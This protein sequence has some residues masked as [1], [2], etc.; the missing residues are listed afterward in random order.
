MP[1]RPDSS[2]IFALVVVVAVFCFNLLC[3]YQIASADKFKQASLFQDDAYYYILIA[4]NIV[5]GKGVS[6]DGV[7]PTTGFQPLY[8]LLTIGFVWLSRIAHISVFKVIF[9]S[10][11]LLTMVGAV[12]ASRIRKDVSAD[13]R[14]WT[15]LIML[16]LLPLNFPLVSKRLACGMEMGLA[17]CMLAACAGVTTRAKKWVK[18]GSLKSWQWLLVGLLFGLLPLTRVDYGLFSA[19]FA[20][21]LLVVCARRTWRIPLLFVLGGIL[22]LFCYAVTALLYFDS[23]I[24]VSFLAKQHYVSQWSASVQPLARL[25]HGLKGA[26]FMWIYPVVY[27]LFGYYWLGG[28]M[29]LGIATAAVLICG[30]SLVGVLLWKSRLKPMSAWPIISI[31]FAT[32]LHSLIFGISGPPYVNPASFWYYAPELLAIVVLWSA[33]VDVGMSEATRLP[34]LLAGGAILIIVASYPLYDFRADMASYEPL[35]RAVDIAA[36]STPETAIIGSWD[37]GFNAYW[38]KPRTTVNLDGMANS[39]E[40]FRRV[41][42][43]GRY[44]E[45]FR[46]S[47]ITHLLNIVVNDPQSIALAEQSYFRTPSIP[48]DHYDILAR[49]PF[50]RQNLTIYLARLK[51]R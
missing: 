11:L 17:I 27:L 51:G 5:D 49:T 21:Y 14:R 22:V 13:S 45:Y 26:T 46:E 35:R 24:P 40:F 4:E 8:Q 16:L 34:R 25:L 48:R 19:L 39:K 18:D 30:A 23:V 43:T 38:L 15:L 7:N 50:P 44:E 28:L 47:G 37:S 6:C 10:N 2:T 3:W 32:I 36:K 20:M 1:R 41:V 9:F 42:L 12:L 31:F 33:L 29:G